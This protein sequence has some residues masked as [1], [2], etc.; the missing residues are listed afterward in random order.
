MENKLDVNYV[1]NVDNELLIKNKIN[2]MLEQR[3]LGDGLRHF[4]NQKG[5]GAWFNLINDEHRRL[6]SCSD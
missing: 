4:L 5:K 1:D 2:I 3:F 6:L